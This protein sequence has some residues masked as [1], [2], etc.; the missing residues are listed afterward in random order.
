MLKIR[1]M[2]V[3]CVNCVGEGKDFVGG[4]CSLT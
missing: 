1:T 2:W 3:G 4:V